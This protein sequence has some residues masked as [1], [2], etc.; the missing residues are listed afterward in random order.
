MKKSKDVDNYIAKA[1]KELRKKLQE[2]RAII[3]S[4]APQA[5]ERISYGMP[6]YDY[7][8]RLIYFK[9]SKAHLGI[10]VPTPVI[11][12]HK[13]ELKEYQTAKATV[14]FY[15]EAKLPSSL[16]KK[17]VKARMK[18]NEALSKIKLKQNSKT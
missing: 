14:R 9:L 2:L 11:E 5:E 8:G 10:Y 17:L 16:I 18:K 7:K 4:V 6:Y 3:K 15:L 12:E 13:N 1:P